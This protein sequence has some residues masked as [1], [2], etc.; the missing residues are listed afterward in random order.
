MR[1]KRVQIVL[2]TSPTVSPATRKREV[3]PLPLKSCHAKQPVTAAT[4]IA[5][6]AATATAAEARQRARTQGPP[7]PPTVTPADLT[8]KRI[9][10]KNRMKGPEQ[11]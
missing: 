9:A 10:R 4:A 1:G 3:T 11:R 5:V 2:I 6:T 7:A 8:V